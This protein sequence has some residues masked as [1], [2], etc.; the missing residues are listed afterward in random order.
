MGSG[1][2]VE[3]KA[4]LAGATRWQR[5]FDEALAARR[6][7]RGEEEVR[8]GLFVARVLV[9]AAAAAKEREHAGDDAVEEGGDLVVGRRRDFDEAGAGV[10]VFAVAH[11]D[12]VGDEDV[13]VQR[14]LEGGVEALDEG[15]RAVR[16]GAVG[17][18]AEAAGAAALEGEDDAEHLAQGEDRELRV[19]GEVVAD[20]AR[21]G[22]RREIVD[23]SLHHIVAELPRNRP[24]WPQSGL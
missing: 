3:R 16:V 18:G 21:E 15:D 12:T 20:T 7:S 4:V 23:F 14:Q 8:L 5:I 19:V 24:I 1:A 9:D 11:E 13:E 6:C 17:A 10:E 22:H 2:G